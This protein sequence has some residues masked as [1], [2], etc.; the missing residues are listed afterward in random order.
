MSVVWK[1]Q[2][3]MFLSDRGPLACGRKPP[4]YTHQWFTQYVCVFSSARHD[5]LSA[6]D[7]AL[8][9]D[10]CHPS[11]C[12][13][14]VYPNLYSRLLAPHGYFRFS[15]TIPGID[16]PEPAVSCLDLVLHFLGIA[17]TADGLVPIASHSNYNANKPAVS[18]FLRCYPRD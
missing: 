5:F 10:T 18:L 4:G 11:Y 9:Y 12:D 14:A 8:A 17:S 7:I 2:S 6:I 1:S 13:T 15:V 3:A 16:W